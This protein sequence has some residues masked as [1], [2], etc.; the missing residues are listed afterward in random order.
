[1]TSDMKTECKILYMFTKGFGDLIVKY[2][3][4]YILFEL[5]MLK[6]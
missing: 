3:I 5:T 2:Y 1:M 4:L 6:P